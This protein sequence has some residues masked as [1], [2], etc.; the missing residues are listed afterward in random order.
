MDMNFP[1][2]FLNHE[3][4]RLE[5]HGVEF[6]LVEPRSLEWAALVRRRILDRPPAAV[7]SPL[8]ET[9]RQLAPQALALLPALALFVHGSDSDTGDPDARTL[10]VVE[11]TDPL[12]EAVRTAQESGVPWRLV[13]PDKGV[14]PALDP[15]EPDTLAAASVA[16]CELMRELLGR[17]WEP[18]SDFDARVVAFH[19]R[20]LVATQGPGVLFVCTADWVRPVALA[21]EQEIAT[22]L[23][24][25]RREDLQV[26]LAHEEI[27]RLLTSEPMGFIKLYEN[28]RT[29]GNLLPAGRYPMTLAL[30]GEARILYEKEF[31]TTLNAS[32]LMPLMKYAR[33]LA[34]T[35]KRLFPTRYDLVVAARSFYDHDFGWLFFQLLT[36]AASPPA[37]AQAPVLQLDPDQLGISTRT[38]H[39]ARKLR[40]RVPRFL[41]AYMDR[42]RE[43]S[44]GAWQTAFDE[45]SMCSYPPE[46]ILIEGTA[47]QMKE[48][49]RDA[50]GERQLR[51]I[52]FTANLLDG[53]DVRETVRRWYEKRLYVHE[54]FSG[55]SKVGSVVIIFDE[56][57]G[58]DGERYPYCAH[59]HGE[60]NQ[61]SDMAFYA[62]EPDEHVVGPGIRRCEYGGLLLTSPPGRMWPVWE[63]PHL[64]FLRRKSQI[65]LA[66]GLQLTREPVVLYI[67]PRPPHAFLKRVALRMGLRVLHLPLGSLS[68]QRIRRLR[69]FHIL[70]GHQARSW[71]HRFIPDP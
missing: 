43:P 49:G 56:D 40:Q 54:A 52:P 45:A 2:P 38:V 39:F 1:E 22:P 35:R 29:T 18:C 41:S 10:H 19:L 57:E 30:L 32:L 64:R 36:G 6:F 48:K 61:E 20:E 67:A 4:D 27:A 69:S 7:A 62:T 25:V 58:V 11:A 24:R 33:N 17:P 34:L 59:W 5:M 55:R 16:P 71:A 12:W 31:S 37:G 63:D 70:S 14:V 53:V 28:W 13:A 3:T 23:R 51:A 46:D 60:H 42:P 68:P 15:V 66:A 9:F 50:I 26:M 8:P 65:L 44:P 21:L 47:I